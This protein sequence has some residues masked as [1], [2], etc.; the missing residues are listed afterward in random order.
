MCEY[1]YEN[2]KRCRLKP[3][4]GSKYCPLHIPREEGE[5][6]YGEKIRG[7]KRGL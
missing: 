5:A 6:L 2:G 1:T 4:D 3:L 7:I